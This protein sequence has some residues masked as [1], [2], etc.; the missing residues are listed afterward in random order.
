M[1]LVAGVDMDHLDAEVARERVHHLLGLVQAQQPVVDEHAG[2]LVADRL[3]DQRRRDRRIDA[4]RQPED[5]L[6]GADLLA[7][8]ADRL[9]DVV[10]HV[11]VAAR[12]RRCRA[13]KRA[14]IAAPCIVCVTSGW[15]C[16]A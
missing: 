11:P 14:R 1:N 4:A 16:T 15:N 10:G 5:H 6:F 9:A 8:P 13:T 2:Q 12:S 7:D 3:V